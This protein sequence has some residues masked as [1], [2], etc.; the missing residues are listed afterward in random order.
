MLTFA[1]SCVCCACGECA[2][3]D[4]L[5]CACCAC[6]ECNDDV[7]D[8]NSDTYPSYEINPCTN[9]RNSKKSLAIELTKKLVAFR[10]ITPVDDGCLDFIANY[11]K[12]KGFAI[13]WLNC[14]PVK[15]L[16]AQKG[17]GRLCFAGHVDVVPPGQG[18]LSDPFT[19]A[20]IDSKLIGRGVA[21]MKGA[22]ACW[23]ALMDSANNVSML[24][25]SDEEGQALEGL[26]TTTDFLKTKNI[27]L[28]ILGEPTAHKFVGDC[29]K[30]GRRGSVTTVLDIYGKQGHI[31]YPEYAQNP[32]N[33]AEEVFWEIQNHLKQTED[34]VFGPCV[35]ERTFISTND[36]AENV[37]PEHAQMRFGIR[38][39][40][41][42]TCEEIVALI[43][44]VCKEKLQN[45]NLKTYMHGQAFVIKD[46]KLLESLR[47]IFPQAKW[48]AKGAT[49]DGRFLTYVAPVLE[50]GFLE[51]QAHQ[52]NEEI[53]IT[54]IEFLLHIYKKIIKQFS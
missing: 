32:I 19:C 31:A 26:R 54:D 1:N 38:I 22:V 46:T 49:S 20:Q 24:L 11:L 27:Q 16:Y 5:E 29:F 15:N 13:T 35:A 25:T 41:Q 10:S 30:I 33:L 50:C 21:D 36:T 44:T 51:Q 48:D 39:N 53:S 7:H 14:G 28:F 45:F 17:D 3:T 23:M 9:R 2:C 42:K 47:A 12:D 18:W 34:P 6:C 8:T 43:K 37:T 52:V 40:T 4:N